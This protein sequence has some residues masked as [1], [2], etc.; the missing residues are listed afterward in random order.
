M[1]GVG[2][3]NSTLIVLRPDNNSRST[4]FGDLKSA[5]GTFGDF[6]YELSLQGPDML[7][8][9]DG[10][11]LEIH[12]RNSGPRGVS[13]MTKR[14]IQPFEGREGDLPLVTMSKSSN[15]GNSHSCSH[16]STAVAE[17]EKEGAEKEKE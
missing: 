3:E 9:E 4:R 8:F 2:G 17:K 5:S 11:T 16:F 13:I 10:D 6:G 14:N 15:L 1:P 7:P 12:V